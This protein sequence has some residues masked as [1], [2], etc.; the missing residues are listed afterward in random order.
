MQRSRYLRLVD[1]MLALDPEATGLLVSAPG[2]TELAG[3]HTDHQHGNVLAA[4]VDLDC[5]A[6]IS[7]NRQ[8]LVELVSAGIAEPIVVS[9]DD[10]SPRPDER[11]KPAALVRGMAAMI[12][13]EIGSI[14]GFRGAVHSTC[15][16]GA[17][18]STSA[19]FSVLIGTAFTLLGADRSISA[20][21]LARMAQEAENR[22][23]GKP[24][25]LMDQMSSA[26][27]GILAIDFHQ[28][29]Q[30]LLQP[31]PLTVTLAGYSLVVV[32][33]GGDHTSLTAEY[34]AI[35]EEMRA[36]ARVLGHDSGRGVTR[37]E[38]LATLP[39]I[40]RQAGDR[41]ALRLLHFVEE[42]LR[43]QRMRRALA[44]GDIRSYLALVRASGKSSCMLLQNCAN[45]GNTREQGILLGL[46]VSE[47][48]C[49]EAVARVHGGGFAGTIQAYVP[50]RDL[51]QY[52]QEMSGIFGEKA[53][54]PLRIGRP[55]ACG[56][57]RY[58]SISLVLEC[59]GG[60]RWPDM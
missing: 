1:R 3:N 7:P 27:G 59:Q 24:C 14:S 49:P 18:L 40:R 52:S 28:P 35:P 56:L 34:A 50:H 55:G 25:G 11:G 2:R 19:A 58:G 51:R 23:F 8:P 42:D 41:A 20:E 31:L 38:L 21:R 46:A 45:P 33:T 17:G 26:V 16:S 12:A 44:A 54:I 47:R 30:P 48:F 15:P 4:A 29:E 60:R 32:D 13:A 5:V 37:D 57:H 6:A 10:L 39:A 43:A 36:A 22:Y 9:L 53:V